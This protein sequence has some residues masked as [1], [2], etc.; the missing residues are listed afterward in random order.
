MNYETM[1]VD[2]LEAEM[3]RLT[4]ERARLRAEALKVQAVL[5][6]QYAA[7]RAAILL[8]SMSDADKAALAQAVTGAGGIASQE[9]VTGF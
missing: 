4:E 3:K 1:T 5:D 6:R 7:M 2:Q 8:E 9:S